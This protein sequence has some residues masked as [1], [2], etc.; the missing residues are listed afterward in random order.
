[1]KQSQRIKLLQKKK[2]IL[3]LRDSTH[4]KLT[5]MNI[6]NGGE[7]RTCVYMLHNNTPQNMSSTY[8][9]LIWTF[10]TFI[11]LNAGKGT[12]SRCI[13]N[14]LQTNMAECIK[15]S[16]PLKMCFHSY[17]YAGTTL[18]TDEG[19]E[20]CFE[21]RAPHTTPGSFRGWW[22]LRGLSACD[23]AKLSTDQ[24]YGRFTNR[25]FK[26]GQHQRPQ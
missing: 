4:I 21:H 16:S 5:G 14:T 18:H 12:T 2:N 23:P 17:R 6:Y 20:W 10:V 15:T 13:K 3:N 11:Y 24:R 19:G 1:M 7:C 22:L 26:S 8:L 9:H 25:M